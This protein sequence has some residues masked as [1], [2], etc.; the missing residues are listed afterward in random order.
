MSRFSE[1]SSFRIGVASLLIFL[2]P[3][4]GLSATPDEIDVAIAKG[5]KYVLRQQR[6]TGQ[7]EKD[8]TRV[9]TGHDHKNMQGDTFGGFTAVSTYALLACGAKPTDPQ[10]AKAIDFLRKADVIGIYALGLRSNVW[11]LIPVTA[12]NGAWLN[13]AIRKDRDLLIN[14][15]NMKA[16]INQWFW[17]YGNGRGKRLDLSVSQYGVLGLWA[18]QQAGAEVPVETWRMLD[19]HWRDIQFPDGAWAY[20]S[21]PT[22][23]TIGKGKTSASMTAA[24]VA[25]LFITQDYIYAEKGSACNGNITNDNIEK[26][27]AWMAENFGKADNLYSIYGVERIGVASGRKYFGTHDWFA[28]DADRLVKWQ[29]PD[30]SWQPNFVGATPEVATS[31]ALLFLSRGRAPVLV[32]KLDY[33][34][35]N[36]APTAAANAGG[37][38]AT[39]AHWNQRPRDVAN[40]LRWFIRQS[41]RDVNWQIVSLKAPAT[42]LIEAPVLYIS[43]DAEL[44]FTSDEM[45]KLRDFVYLGGLIFG[46]ADCANDGFAKSFEKLGN[47]LFGRQFRDLPQRHPI[48]MLEQYPAA[49]W[50]SKP[51]VRALSNDVREFMLLVPQADPGRAWQVRADQTRAELFQLGADAFMYAVDKNPS[52]KGRTH[53]ILPDPK[54]VPDRKLAIARLQLGDNWDPEPGSWKRMAAVLHN[55]ARIDLATTPAKLDAAALAPFK[56][57][58]L[59]GTTKIKLSDDQR[60]VLLEWANRGGTLIIDAAGGSSD[61]ADSMEAELKTIFGSDAER[62]LSDTLQPDHPMFN[63]PKMAI[64]SV[65]YRPFARSVLVGDLRSPRIRAIQHGGRVLVFYSREDLTEGMVGQNVDGVNGYVPASATELMRNLV[66][67]AG[68]SRRR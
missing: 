9:G 59:T 13:A 62:G 16:G 67:F 25:T 33:N 31:Y 18:C 65:S 1:R 40:V 6:P 5:Q 24:G 22:V 30:G 35:A 11:Q 53:V 46:N 23:A 28:E 57:A 44:S 64:Q 15:I 34:L 60:A 66:V 68:F 39:A 12:E 48:Y 55:D 2:L 50:K 29:K 32:N 27:V 37:Q 52:V 45:N 41:E 47:T 3:A 14:G 26:G 61:F 21:T 38:T 49:N 36:A 4:T 51:V 7:W 19:R 10:M 42:E 8:A 17:E 56:V 43:G 58:H 20:D 54:I 63:L